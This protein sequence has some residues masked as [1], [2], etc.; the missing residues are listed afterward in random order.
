MNPDMEKAEA[1]GASSWQHFKLCLKEKEWPKSP[2]LAG[3]KWPKKKAEGFDFVP[4]DLQPING[5]NH[6]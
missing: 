1:A 5:T 3:V 2:V 4:L 6:L